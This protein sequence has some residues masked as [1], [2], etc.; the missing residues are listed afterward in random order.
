MFL[1]L[2]NY[3]IPIW[4]LILGVL[5]LNEKV[6]FIIGFGLIFIT[7]GVWLIEKKN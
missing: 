5:L 6:D 3:L 7:I 2:V 1:S 4:A